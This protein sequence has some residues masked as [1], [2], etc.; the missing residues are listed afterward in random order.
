MKLVTKRDRR[1]FYIRGN[2]LDDYRVRMKWRKEWIIL[3][4]VYDN[5]RNRTRILLA[6]QK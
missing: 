3:E 4:V 2:R 1:Y 6:R 5:I